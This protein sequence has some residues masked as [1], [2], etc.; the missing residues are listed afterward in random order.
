MTLF[1]DRSVVLDFAIMEYVNY[2]ILLKYLKILK[3]KE[4]CVT[5][6][7]NL[8]L[9]VSYFRPHLEQTCILVKS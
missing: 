5:V 7:S 4:C 2:I 8:E 9:L 1:T 3:F 6:A